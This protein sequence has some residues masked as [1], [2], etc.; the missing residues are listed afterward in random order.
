MKKSASLLASATG[1]FMRTKGTLQ[2]CLA[3]VLPVVILASFGTVH[4]QE[5][6]PIGYESTLVY[7]GLSAPAG[8]AVDGSGNV[9]IADYS[10][11]RVLLETFQANGTY[12]QSTIGSGL[13]T[14]HGVAVDATGKVFIADTGNHRVVEEV[15]AGG[16]AYTQ[17][18]L[19]PAGN[20]YIPNPTGIAVDGADNVYLTDPNTGNVVQLTAASSYGTLNIVDSAT[21][22][23]GIQTNL[24]YGVAVDSNLNVFIADVVQGVIEVPWTGSA[25]GTSTTIGTGISNPKGV[26]VDLQNNVYVANSGTGQVYEEVLQFNGS[27]AQQI[28]SAT[29]LTSVDSLAVDNRANIYVSVPN[30]EKVIEL[31]PFNGNFG[32]VNIGSTSPNITI[33]FQFLQPGT[34]SQVLAVQKG[35]N[36]GEFNIV[37]GGTCTVGSSFNQ[38]DS[39]SVIV[40]FTP[41]YAGTRYGAVELM[42]NYNELFGTAYIFGTGVGPQVVFLPG[43]TNQVASDYVAGSYPGLITMAVDGSDNL[44]YTDWD[45]NYWHEA[46]AASNYGTIYTSSGTIQVP[47]DVQTDGAGNVYVT[48]YQLGVI[49][50]FYALD[51]YQTYISMDTGLNN[52]TGSAIDGNGNVYV[53]AGGSGSVTEIL[54]SSDYT[55]IIGIANG[56]NNPSDLGVDGSGDVFVLNFGG[57]NGSDFVSEIVAVNG[58]VPANPVINTVVTGLSNP[59]SIKVD[60]VGNLYIADWQNNAVEEWTVASGYATEIVLVNVGQPSD[61]AIDGQ[62]NLFYNSG[63][64]STTGFIYEISEGTAPT[65]YFTGANNPQTVTILNIGNEPLS[66]PALNTGNNPSISNGFTWDTSANTDCQLAPYSLAIQTQCNFPVSYNPASGV[67]TGQLVLTDNTLYAQAPNYGQQIIPLNATGLGSTMTVTASSYSIPYGQA[68]PTYAYQLNGPQGVTMC[69]G[70]PTLSTNPANPTAIGSYPITITQGS[71]NCGAQYTNYVF[72]NGTLTITE[73]ITYLTL[74]TTNAG[75]IPYGSAIPN[76]QSDYSLTGFVNRDTQASVCTGAPVISTLATNSSPAGTYTI[77]GD[78]GSLACTGDPTVKYIINVV[79]SGT[80]IIQAQPITVT[81][82]AVNITYGATPGYSSTTVPSPLP[83][84]CVGTIKYNLSGTPQNPIPVGTYTITPSGLNCGSNYTITY[85]TAKLTV[86]KD[87][88]VVTITPTSLPYGAAINTLTYSAANSNNSTDVSSGGKWTYTWNGVGENGNY[89]PNSPGTL[90]AVWAPKKSVIPGT[91]PHRDYNAEYNSSASTCIHVTDQAAITY[92][93]QP[94]SIPYG[95]GLVANQLGNAVTVTYNNTN[96]T[97]DGTSTFVYNGITI[98]VGYILPGGTDSVCA[99]WTPTPAYQ[100]QYSPLTTCS[101]IIVNASNTYVQYTPAPSTITYGTGLVGTQLNAQAFI[102]N[103]NTNVTA[104][105]TFTYTWNGNPVGLGYVLPVGTQTICANWT[106]SA[107]YSADLLSSSL[108]QTINVTPSVTITAT[109]TTVTYGATP[110]FADTTNPSPLPAQ[111]S[112]TVV[113]TVTPNPAYTP[114]PVGGYTITPSGITCTGNYTVNY[115]TGS[116]TVNKDAPTVSYSNAPIPYGTA[117]SSIAVTAVNSNNSTNVLGGGSVSYT[118]AGTTEPATFIPPYGSGQL[119]VTWTPNASLISGT[120]LAYSSEYTATTNCQNITV[121]A[122]VLTITASPSATAV[123]GSTLPNSTYTYVITGFVGND[124]SGFLS[125]DGVT[126]A[127]FGGSNVVCSGQPVLSTPVDGQSNP[128]PAM[129]IYTVNVSTAGFACTGYAYKINTGELHI[130]PATLTIQ[131]VAVSLP[132][133]S[134]VPTYQYNCYLNGT[135][136]GTNTCGTGATAVT[137]APTITSTA[138]ARAS[139]TPGVVYYTSNVG[140]YNLNPTW[141]SLKSSTGD[142]TFKFQSNTLTLTTTP[143]ALT[144]QPYIISLHQSTCLTSGVPT[145]AYKITGL[146]NWDTQA[147]TTT[148]APVLSIPTYTGNCAK[149]TYTIQ[150][151]AGTLALDVY[152]GQTDYSGI[153]YGTATLTIF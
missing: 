48:D 16:G 100:S 121:T 151:A 5:A 20:T 11:N 137:G 37:S 45:D 12:V 2:Q 140:A 84:V 72:V 106:A 65:L 138:S 134:R 148:G 36:N 95:T 19:M 35:N 101:N 113:N 92:T 99:T 122:A 98:G 120:S 54:A 44:F 127:S 61:M 119:C 15:P 23:S 42:N 150:S 58:A 69:T 18:V 103:V 141:G 71:L 67:S 81:A 75:T 125:N 147:S 46:T 85:K 24:P 97:A 111:C 57:G 144:V 80:L 118:W 60:N 146:I 56:F 1:R 107:N 83:G 43:V 26:A 53:T 79:N 22:G 78:V 139:S 105:G 90:C 77:L 149:G 66:F 59:Q 74:T 13:L 55:Q 49:Y 152:G 115:V 64:G 52:P 33:N 39:C 142:Y 124:G 34:L 94:N 50:K 104:D 135:L 41:Q 126:G 63:T 76:L 93:P 25:F 30:A 73:Q 131:P 47:S 87:T 8:V 109:P 112:G 27:Y 128:Y 110:S 70:Q 9:Y 7:Q 28:I 102:Q 136:L 114:D 62:G 145:P 51:G 3:F 89:V 129:G 108:C 21:A 86:T 68:V 130:T 31:S 29:G 6:Y 4:A 32:N 40:N 88:P 123:Y 116:L 153:N 14:P 10:N 38:G 143:L 82:N 96:V 91:H 117:L 132:Y 17:T 133:G